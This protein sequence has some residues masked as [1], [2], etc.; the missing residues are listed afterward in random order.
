MRE[1]VHLSGLS[2]QAIYAMGQG[3]ESDRIFSGALKKL[4]DNHAASVN[5]VVDSSGHHH[6]LVHRISDIRYATLAQ[7]YLPKK[8]N[9]RKKADNSEDEDGQNSV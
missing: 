9:K 4:L 1:L 7:Y 3:P 2:E 5:N 6:N 8:N